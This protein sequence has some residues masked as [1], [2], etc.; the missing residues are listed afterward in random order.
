[1]RVSLPGA[2][3]HNDLH[4]TIWGVVGPFAFFAIGVTQ[5][6]GILL[7]KLH[8]KE[9]GNPCVIR[10]HVHTQELVHIAFL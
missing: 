8:S 10:D 2:I 4:T 5:V 9:I 3:S 7:L 1:M 6:V